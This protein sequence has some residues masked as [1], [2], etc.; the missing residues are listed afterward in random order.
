MSFIIR[1]DLN[2]TLN[3]TDI[4]K[5]ASDDYTLQIV[6]KK[7]IEEVKSYIQHRYDVDL[8]FTEMTIYDNS[9]TYVVN[10]NVYFN[11]KY[12][13]NILES[14][15]NYPTNTTYFTEI[16]D[17]RDQSILDITC[18]IAI[19]YLFRRIT[20]RI[21]PKWIVSEYDRVRD[22]LKAYQKGTRTIIL[23]V[24][25]D[26]DGDEEGHR[27]TYTSETQKDWNF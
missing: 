26:S 16:D 8:V 22:D 17:P 6:I 15:A 25:E 5:M 21:T 14:T 23:P 20:P 2:S 12:Y 7:A 4:N 13:V 18:I 1:N 24:N 9:V 27:I 3:D 11:E 19:Y 10:D